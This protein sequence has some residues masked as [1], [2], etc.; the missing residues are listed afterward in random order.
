MI[1]PWSRYFIVFLSGTLIAGT[2][3]GKEY[4]VEHQLICIEQCG[5]VPNDGEEDGDAIRQAIAQA[6]ASERPAVIQFG[7]GCYHVSAGRGRTCFPIRGARNLVLKGQGNKTEII[8]TDPAA[9]VFGATLCDGVTFKDFLIDYDPLPFTQGRIVSVDQTNGTFDLDVDPGFPLLSEPWFA[10]ASDEHG[11]WGMIFDSQEDRLKTGAGDHVR[12]A[13]WTHIKERIWRIQPQSH[14]RN[15]LRDMKAGDRFVHLARGV[16]GTGIALRG[17]RNSSIEDVTIYAGPST[18]TVLVANEKIH[19]RGLV[20]CRRPGSSRLLSTDADGVHCQQNRVG[21]TI[22]DC[23]FSGM[24]DDSINVYAP[25]NV[26][27]EV[28]SPTELLVTAQCAIR[29][30][31]TV[32]IMDP[33]L[34]IVRDE[35]A[36]VNVAVAPRRRLQITLE[37]A[38]DGI[39]SGTDHTNAD[40]LYNLSACGAGYVIRNNEMTVH[41]RHGMLLRAGNGLVE[42][43]RIRA[44]AGFGIV[45]T[46][47]PNWPE[48]PFA[49]GVTIRNN[50]IEGVGYAKGYGSSRNGAAIQIKGTKLG[51]GL[52]EGRVQRN[53]VVERNRIVDPPGAGVFIG[54]AQQ[55]KLNG[56]RIEVS[57]GA[58][59][60]RQTAG[61]LL[62]NSEGVSIDGLTITG[63]PQWF[64][65]AVEIDPTVSQGDSGVTIANVETDGKAAATDLLDRR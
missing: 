60:H 23:K 45:V 5:A 8:V 47:E 52:A 62:T 12:L 41:R 18:A 26:V 4:D 51:H 64:T 58:A 14:M 55:V 39:Q 17:C 38:V 7:E 11:K 25:P 53:I 9:G 10:E 49:D 50:T 63:P 35:V 20:V 34:G 19:V 1:K 44:V 59:S 56:N 37:R 57:D 28:R 16:G 65:A 2:T 43:N 33:R 29:P 21:P 22:E 46:N 27:L 40:T 36:V 3:L 61:I 13:T 15:R 48:G 32:Q 42:G 54:A 31:D 24:A 6:I 30:G